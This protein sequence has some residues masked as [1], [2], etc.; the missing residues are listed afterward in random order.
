MAVVSGDGLMIESIASGLFLG[1]VA[2]AVPGWLLRLRESER[3]RARVIVF[4]AL[5]SELG[6]LS[7]VEYGWWQL[8]DAAG[9]VIW[10][11]WMFRCWRR[12]EL[13]RRLEEA[14]AALRELG[15]WSR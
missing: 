9:A 8:V 1:A 11:A 14:A 12:M 6:L 13:A 3:W 2:L 7:T 4:A 15:R 5:G 10:F